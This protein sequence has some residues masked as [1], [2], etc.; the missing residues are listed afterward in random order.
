MIGLRRHSMSMCICVCVCIYINKCVRTHTHTHTVDYYSAI[1][2]NE[3]LP[4]EATC[5]QNRNRLTDAENKL[6]VTKQERQRDK[7]V[8]WE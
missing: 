5:I 4:F 1:K 7:L 3:T 8:V 2:K 6:I